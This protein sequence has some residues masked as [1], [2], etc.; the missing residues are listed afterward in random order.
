MR[1]EEFTVTNYLH[2]TY[3]CSV[4]TSSS[5]SITYYRVLSQRAILFLA[6]PLPLWSLHSRTFGGACSADPRIRASARGALPRHHTYTRTPSAGVAVNRLSRS[7]ALGLAPM[8]SQMA[9]SAHPALRR[10]VS[11]CMQIMC[12]RTRTS[13]QLHESDRPR[14]ERRTGVGEH[15]G[16]T[17]NIMHRWAAP[18]VAP[19]AALTDY[20]ARVRQI[21]PGI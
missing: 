5:N 10:C 13:C 18:H 3:Y 16:S 7:A 14:C 15:N 2:T 8:R 11:A 12:R 21:A 9:G 20:F 1:R 17:S 4:H 19:Y 6:F